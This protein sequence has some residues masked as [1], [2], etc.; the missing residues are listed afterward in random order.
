[1]SQQPVRL[2]SFL[3][4]DLLQFNNINLDKWTEM[5]TNSFY[6]DYLTKY[7]ELCVVA[8]SLDGGC[9]AGYLIAKV[10]GKGD[11]WHSHISALSVS[12]E[13][14]KA[15]VAR[16]LCEYFEE[17]SEVVHNCFFADLF[18]R[19]T[20]V[21]AIQVYKNRGYVVYRTIKNYYDGD[22]DAF[23]MRKPLKRDA[24][25]KSIARAGFTIDVSKLVDYTD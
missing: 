6:F 22:A 9:L 10:E 24:Q 5:Y 25:K 13:F 3:V 18:V 19:S 8:E 21:L 12:P 17:L 16:L 2:R 15:G 23:D 1:M 7:P 20:N 11:E 4:D 14:R